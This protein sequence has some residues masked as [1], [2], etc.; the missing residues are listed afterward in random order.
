MRDILHRFLHGRQQRQAGRDS[1]VVYESDAERPEPWWFSYLFRSQ[2]YITNRSC[3][4]RGHAKS[5]I[6]GIAVHLL[7]HVR[8]HGF[9]K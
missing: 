6:M 2:P 8:L 7:A 9:E 3:H 4:L 1:V 5:W